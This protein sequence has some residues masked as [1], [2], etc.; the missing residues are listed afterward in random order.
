MSSI[1]I[2]KNDEIIHNFDEILRNAAM[3]KE[4]NIACHE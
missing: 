4:F 3:L 1:T 2:P